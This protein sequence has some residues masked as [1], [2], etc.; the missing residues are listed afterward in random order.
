MGDT[1]GRHTVG[2][3][4]VATREERLTRP[5]YFAERQLL[6]EAR[7]RGYQRAE[8]M[9]VGGATGALV[10]SVTFLEKLAPAPRAV[11][12]ELL[13]AAWVVLL[14]CLSL[15]LLGQYSSARSFDHELAR[16]DAA[17][18]T[19]G[20]GTNRWNAFNSVCGGTAAVLL[21]VGVTLLALFAYLN[22]PFQKG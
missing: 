18:H 7:Q 22:A 11:R 16:L 12:T 4:D 5:E 15:S 20:V 8:Q 21:I 17:L 3:G 6:L 14:I 13:V 1:S 10:L 2:H 19:E 9:V